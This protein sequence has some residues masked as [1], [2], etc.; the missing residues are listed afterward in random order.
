MRKASEAAMIPGYYFTAHTLGI[1]INETRAAFEGKWIIQEA[2]DGSGDEGSRNVL[3]GRS[4]TGAELVK[5]V[6]TTETEECVCLGR[7]QTHTG[8]TLENCFK[9][10]GAQREKEKCM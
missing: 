4:T 3:D 5:L 7:Q 6:Q 1:N 9:I 10:G 8:A 2:T